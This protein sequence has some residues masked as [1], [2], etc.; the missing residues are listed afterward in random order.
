VTRAAPEAR[1]FRAPQC[2]QRPYSRKSTQENALRV[3]I[4]LV[5]RPALGAHVRLVL[6]GSTA[7]T[8]MPLSVAFYVTN[9]RSF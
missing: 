6:R 5:D 7:T 9:W 2:Q 8:G 4:V 1:I 3:S